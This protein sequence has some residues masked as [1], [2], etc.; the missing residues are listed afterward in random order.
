MRLE[1]ERKFL[2]T[3]RGWEEGSVPEEI[4]QGYLATDSE[5]S[6]RVRVKGDQAFLT[7][8]GLIRG[9]SRSEFEYAIPIDD[10]H[11]ML[12][13][14]CL[15][16]LVEK[17]RYTLPAGDLVWEIDEFRGDNAGLVVAEIELP[18]EHTAFDR[19]DWLGV[20]VSSDAR[21]YNA[22]LVEHPFSEWGFPDGGTG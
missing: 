12:D 18:D 3:G 14:L 1:I 5:R 4:R 2:V 17:V 6:V 8:K 15:R 22:N 13:E 7:I 9:I 10:A 11:R 20:E 19:P 21:Y 16:P